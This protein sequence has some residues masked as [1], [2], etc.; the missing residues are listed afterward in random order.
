MWHIAH[1]INRYVW[2][3]VWKCCHFQ[4]TS[5][6]WYVQQHFD[7]AKVYYNKNYHV[8]SKSGVNFQV[9]YEQ[10]C[11]K[12]TR[13][14]QDL[15]VV[16]SGIYIASPVITPQLNTFC[17]DHHNSAS[18]SLHFASMVLI[19]L[20][21]LPFNAILQ[22]TSSL[23]LWL[24]SNGILG[25]FQ[26]SLEGPSISWYNSS[27]APPSPRAAQFWQQ[28]KACWGCLSKCSELP[29]TKFLTCKQFH[30]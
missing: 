26:D 5:Y 27:S 6:R 8:N 12:R 7:Q 25:C 19:S 14:K 22:F 15:P 11:A 10:N 20:H 30:W 18:A 21:L 1:I 2:L 13:V 4:L 28:F 9:A 3:M 24:S 17:E 16:S 23:H 29:Q